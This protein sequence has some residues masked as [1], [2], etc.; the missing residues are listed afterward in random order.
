MNL[1]IYV[2]IPFCKSRCSYCDFSTEVFKNLESIDRYVFAL[3]KEIESFEA[4]PN[5]L[6]DTI[7]FGGGTPSLLSPLQL[8]QI[9]STLTQKFTFNKDFE[10]TLEMNPATVTL[11][12]LLAYQSIGVNRASFGVQTFNDRA[13]KVLARGHNSNDA[14]NTFS[15]LRESGFQNVSFDLIAGLPNQTMN[16][17]ENNLNEALA[18]DPEHL[19]LYILEI[20]EST[21]LATQINS[22]RQPYPDPDLS[23][24]MYE[25]LVDLVS[26]NGFNQYETSNFA[27]LDFDSRHN[28]KYWRC[29]P[30]IGFGVSAHSFDGQSMRWSNEPDTRK[31]VELIEMG[32]SPIV[33]KIKLSQREL[34]AEY[35]FLGLRLKKGLNLAEFCERFGYDILEEFKNEIDERESLG[36]VRIENGMLRLTKKGFI[37]SNEVFEIFV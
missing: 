8:E 36:L 14:R 12:K 27:K 37:F 18:L 13:L 20:H 17:W 5:V 15:L 31:Y 32:C 19:S 2:H 33:E 3:C 34:S 24:K 23:A 6:I 9:I 4:E 26:E 28:L 1:G 10:F 22:Q 29:E 21:P 25:L 30:V 16:D 35:A 7:Y 11:E